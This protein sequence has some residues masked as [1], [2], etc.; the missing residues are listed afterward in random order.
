MLRTLW[1]HSEGSA[2]GFLASWFMVRTS[3]TIG[4]SKSHYFRE[5]IDLSAVALAQVEVTDRNVLYGTVY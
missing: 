4:E 2:I 1:K 3:L 5:V